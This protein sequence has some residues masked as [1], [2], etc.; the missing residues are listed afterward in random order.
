MSDVMLTLPSCFTMSMASVMR[1]HLLALC[2]TVGVYGA[3]P[4]IFG[5]NII[6][7]NDSAHGSWC[8]PSPYSLQL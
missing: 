5:S 4:A 1:L 8:A 7:W 2:L 6:A 3:V